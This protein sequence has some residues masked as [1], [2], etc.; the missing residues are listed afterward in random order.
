MSV[1]LTTLLELVK[2]YDIKIV[3]GKKGINRMVNWIHMVENTEIASFLDGQEIAIITGIGLQTQE[4]LID[5]VEGIYEHGGSGVIVNIGP[6]IHQISPNVVEFCDEHAL[7][8]FKV[9]WSVHMAYIMRL[10]SGAITE[11]EK[12]TINLNA[13]LKKAIISPER[14]DTYIKD[15]EDNNYMEEWNY[16][17]EVFSILDADNQAVDDKRLDTFK[18]LIETEISFHEWT[19]S[20]LIYENMIVVVYAKYEEKEIRELSQIINKKCSQY[21][22]KAEKM[23][24]GVGKVGK[25][26]REIGKSYNQAIKMNQFLRS[27]E[28]RS[29]STFS[30]LGIYKLLL[31]IDDKSILSEFVNETIGPIIEYDKMNNSEYLMVLSTYLKNSGRVNDTAEE[32]FVHRNTINYKLNKI[33]ELVGMNLSEFD[34]R[35][36]LSIGVKI[37]EILRNL[38]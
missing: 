14:V 37:Y 11:S 18:S 36:M 5:L 13:A 16:C 2:E 17:V 35:E 20:V 31:S 28:D 15:L 9:P 21:L 38:K 12:K 3:A 6:Y 23:Y 1:K 19:A 10:F 26:A 24:H 22:H 4:D 8:L 7:P 30:D 27:K 29:I 33:E 34:E 25:N 32:L